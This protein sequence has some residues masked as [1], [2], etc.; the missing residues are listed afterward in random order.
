MK[1]FILSINQTF[2]DDSSDRTVATVFVNFKNPVEATKIIDRWITKRT[3]GQIT[4]IKGILNLLFI[5]IML[6]L[7]F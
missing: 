4:S 6:K 3:K 2:L 5:R 7:K 1:H